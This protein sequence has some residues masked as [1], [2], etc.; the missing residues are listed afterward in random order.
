MKKKAKK[1]KKGQKYPRN[2]TRGLAVMIRQSH[3]IH[4]KSLH[5]ANQFECTNHR[6]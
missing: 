6:K 1:A 4:Q 5:R 3:Q 2:T